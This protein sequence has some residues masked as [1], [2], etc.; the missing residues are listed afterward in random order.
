MTQGLRGL[1]RPADRIRL[2]RQAD[3]RPLVIVEGDSDRLL[4]EGA[5]DNA[6]PVFPVGGR[7]AALEVLAVVCNWGLEWVGGVVDRDFDDEV[8]SCERM[9]LP[10]VPFE[11]ADQEAMLTDMPALRR[12]VEE[13][14]GAEK[15]I[16]LGGVERMLGLILSIP[17]QL[18][19]LRR[20]NY[21]RRWTLNFKGV[22][23]EAHIVK[24][25]LVLDVNSYVHELMARS[26]TGA[27]REVLLEALRAPIDIGG[28]LPYY[29][30]RDFLAVLSV[31]VRVWRPRKGAGW[32]AEKLESSLRVAATG[33]V[34][35]SLWFDELKSQL[36]VDVA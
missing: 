3:K 13:I 4:L 31:A 17:V 29:R 34:S 33:D 16:E 11:N 2:H 22:R 28:E 35:R 20:M 25:D 21:L 15:V 26:Q 14:V 9:Q 18:G 7:K 32:T 6:V 8:L 19:A 30:G 27:T 36:Y 24:P 23:L 10:V 5:F 12:L 1:D